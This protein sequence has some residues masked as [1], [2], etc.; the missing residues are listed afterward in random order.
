MIYGFKPLIME[1]YISHLIIASF[2]IILAQLHPL[3]VNAQTPQKISYQSVIR[4]NSNQL[5]NNRSVRLRV[6]ILAD[7]INATPSYVETHLATTTSLG[8]VN[9]E[10]GGGSL[11]SGY[12]AA[13]P[14]SRGKIYMKTE[15][16]L[17]GGTTYSISVTT[18]LLSVP[19]SIYTGDVPVSK[20]GDTVTIGTSKLIIPNTTLLSSSTAPASLYTG[21]VAYYPFNGNAN[22]ESGNGRNGTIK[23]GVSNTTDRNGK[24]NSSLLFDGLDGLNKGVRLPTFFSS[25]TDYSFSLWFQVQDTLKTGHNPAQTILCAVPFGVVSASFNHPYSPGKLMSCIGDVLDWRICAPSNPNSWSLTNK[26]QWHHLIISKSQS[27][28]TYYLDGILVRTQSITSNFNVN[29][30]SFDLGSIPIASGEIFSGKIDD[31]WVYNRLLTQDE[32]NYLS[33]L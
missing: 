28:Y 8:L 30:S 14:W 15:V 13:I 29:V 12:F 27:S 33:K 22:D 2:N 25:N 5:V 19:Y 3:A 4:D 31:I 1:K 10:I 6:S 21:L 26:L 11:V 18:Q 17:T 32:I 24:A 20:R 9:L 7:S 23:N 16:D